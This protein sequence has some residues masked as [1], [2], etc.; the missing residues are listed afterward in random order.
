M[1]RRSLGMFLLLG[2]V[3]IATPPEPDRDRPPPVG[4]TERC[5]PPLPRV[6][7]LDDGMRILVARRPRLPLVHAS[8][9]LRAGATSDP[10]G[11]PGVAALLA[12]CLAQR[13]VTGSEVPFHTALLERGVRLDVHVDWDRMRFDLVA[14]ATEIG[15]ALD[16]MRRQLSSGECPGRSLAEARRGLLRRIED[17]TAYPSRARDVAIWSHLFSAP[18]LRLPPE[19]TAA[20]VRSITAGDLRDFHATRFRPQDLVLVV[21]GQVATEDL[22]AAPALEAAAPSSPPPAV[23]AAVPPPDVILIPDRST[24]LAHVEVAYRLS[25]ENPSLD[26]GLALVNAALGGS[27]GARLNRSLRGRLGLAY[28]ATSRLEI[29]H[30]GTILR[31]ETRV[32]TGALLPALRE[33]IREV[34]RLARSPD[35][36]ELERVRRSYETAF[37]VRFD[38]VGGSARTWSWMAS[39]GLEPS[40]LEGYL[41][42]LAAI[43]PDTFSHRARGLLAGRRIIVIV[44]P[45]DVDLRGAGLGT[46]E[47]LDPVRLIDGTVPSDAGQREK[48]PHARE[49]P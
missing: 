27:A 36:E 40:R 49:D 29:R 25:G 18:R 32:A 15:W 44:A 48:H 37:L 28:A 47:V 23:P 22:P 43:N 7:V 46:V 16:R 12:E 13:P 8:W 38:T 45:P 17:Q 41:D 1:I 34:E 20:S 26:P 21:A 31:V 14:P 3:A 33:I 9:I 10:S 2:S 35:P 30:E 5:R 19:G 11:K 4:P 42:G 24:T 39:L 6:R